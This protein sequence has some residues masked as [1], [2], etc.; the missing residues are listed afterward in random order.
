[1]PQETSSNKMYVLLVILSIAIVITAA[2]FYSYVVAGTA[3]IKLL[4]V[5]VPPEQKLLSVSGS[6]YALV[7]P[8]TATITTGVLTQATTAKEASQKNAASM[9]AVISAI[10]NLGIGDKDIRTSFLSLQPVYS[11]PK[12]GGTP[13]ITGYSASNNV[14]VTTKEIGKLSDI[15]DSSVAAGANQISGISFAVSD[16]KQKQIRQELLAGAVKDADEKA[17]NLARNLNVRIAGVKTS[18]IS[19]VVFPQPFVSGFAEKAAT[20]IQ[21]GESRIT[22]SVQVTYIIE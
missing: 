17:G 15:V 2:G 4:N 10:K 21:P 7:T 8:D 3:G 18:S 19:D 13:T 16:D 14:E 11:F 20:P 22:L 5:T 9:N 12:D 1:M 6:A